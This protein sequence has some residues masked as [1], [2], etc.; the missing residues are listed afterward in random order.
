MYGEGAIGQF[1]DPTPLKRQT[2]TTENN[3]VGGR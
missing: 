1:R 3:F 2:D